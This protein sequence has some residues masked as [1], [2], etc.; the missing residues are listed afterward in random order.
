[1]VAVLMIRKGL[2]L[3]LGLFLVV[4]PAVADNVPVPVE[5]EASPWVPEDGDVISFDV[6]RKGKPFGLHEVTFERDGNGVLRAQTRVDLKAGLGFVT[7]FQYTL[8]AVEIW[9]DDRLVAVTGEVNDN[10]RQERVSAER[11]GPN[12][13][14]EGS[15]FSGRIMGGILPASHWNVGQVTAN[16]LLSTENG[17]LLDVKVVN[18]GPETLI[19]EGQSIPATR[20]LMDSD[21]D[22]SLWYDERGRWLKLA[23]Q[24]RGQDI[25]Y[26]LRRLY[27]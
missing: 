21:I 13:A 2:C 3:F 16:Q 15:A 24:A 6:T 10:G 18:E 14:V 19:V 17:Q 22:V 25:E 8:R 7:L 12:L 5:T 20:Y 23:F 11:D 1:M 26:T 27:D 4:S 9:E